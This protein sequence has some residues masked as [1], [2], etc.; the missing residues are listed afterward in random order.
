MILTPKEMQAAEEAVFARGAVAEDLMEKAG[1]GIAHAIR[2]R[3]PR[4]GHVVAYLGKGHNAGDALVA[5]RQLR[6]WGWKV[7]LEEVAPPGESSPLTQKKR[8]EFSALNAPSRET[9]RSLLVLLDGLLGIGASGPL[10]ENFRERAREM[11]RRRR[12]E[13]AWTVAIDLPTGLDGETGE[14]VQDAVEA[15]FT[16]TIAHPKTGLL[17][18]RAEG[19]VGTLV[20]VPL[21]DIPPPPE[22]GDAGARVLTPPLLRS[23]YRRR[24]VDCYKNRAGHV[25]LFA[26]SPGFTGAAAMTAEA[27]LTAG[28]GLVSLHVPPPIYP[29]LAARCPPEIMVHPFPANLSVETLASNQADVFAMGPGLGPSPETAFLGWLQTEERPVVV[30][31]DGLNLLARHAATREAV[32]DP[33]SRR[34]SL[35]H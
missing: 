2:E 1:L 28:A 22:G 24:T 32:I 11:N 21:P 18:D 23:L 16:L 29:I 17:A 8:A 3:F 13:H 14:T 19:H 12:E 35:R 10:R 20:V 30:D 9:N 5:G 31:A 6:A 4:P 25:T 7:S 15:D 33:W 27:A 26:G 34:R